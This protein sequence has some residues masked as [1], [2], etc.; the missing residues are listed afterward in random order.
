MKRFFLVMLAALG[1]SASLSATLIDFV[2]VEDPGNADDTLP[3]SP[4][5]GVGYSF[6][7]SK[8]EISNAQYAEFLNAVAKTDTYNLYR[9]D[10]G[11]GARGGIT[12]SGSPGS[13]SYTTK[14][15]FDNKPVN[16]VSVFDAL[17]FVNWLHNGQ[18]TGL[19]TASTT[20]DGA[21]TFS[22]AT[23]VGGRNSG[24]RY[25]LPSEDEWYKAAYYDP[26]KTGG[27]WYYPTQSDTQP[28]VALANSVGDIT[29]S[30]PN[31]ANFNFGVDWNSQDGMP[32]TI[33]T[34][35]STSYY[36]TFDQAGNV[37]EWTDS[38]SGSSW[39]SRGGSWG[40]SSGTF[41]DSRNVSQT[42]QAGTTEPNILGF[43]VAAAIPEPSTVFLLTGGALT[44]VAARR[45]Q[46]ATG[47]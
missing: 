13:Y 25:W 43:R 36:G 37:R 40:D 28:I 21:Y 41:K 20:E 10:M 8:Y 26:T 34:A 30:G 11:T 17:R 15:N 46:R 44:L 23:T 47:A 4:Y 35:G 12:R 45:H 32:S 24:A 39:I 42:I 7:I 27:Y 16:F 2:K 38:T 19:Q 31:V 1:L 18:P 29:N 22:G 6:L 5:G 3:G 14:A 9:T 33:G